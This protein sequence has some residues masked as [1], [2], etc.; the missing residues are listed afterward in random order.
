MKKF[1][2]AAISLLAFGLAHA[3]DKRANQGVLDFAV[4]PAKLAAARLVEVDGEPVNAPIS[5]T[6][7]WVDAGDHEITVMA[8]I[9][10]DASSINPLTE[11]RH[12][13]G[14]SQGKTTITVVA[15]KRY[16]IAAMADDDK[17]HWEPVI[18]KEE[19][20]KK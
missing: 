4:P 10:D 14:P 16:K 13:G 19:D 8:M 15:G 17:G 2:I 12:V 6:S 3:D 20:L 5:K 7:F 11:S 1:M 9:E 18:W